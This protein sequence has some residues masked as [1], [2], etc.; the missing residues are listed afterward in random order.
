[1]QQG[2]VSRPD[3]SVGPNGLAQAGDLTGRLEPL[4]VPF[5]RF[6]AILRRHF[7]IVLLV[8]V[9]TVG[10]TAFVVKGIAKQY[11]SEASI[12]IEPQRTQVSD[13]QAISPDSG[14]V[15]SLVRTQIDILKS[16]A[17][18]MG[19]VRALHLTDE[20]EFGRHGE[21]LFAFVSPL[22]IKLGLRQAGPVRPPTEEDT[23][24]LAAA[25]LSAK[26]GFANETRSGVLRV[27][28]TTH[29]PDLSA[30]I[31]NSVVRQFLDFKRQEKFAA[32]QRAHD[33]FQ[34]QMREL[35]DQVR[36]AEQEVEK[37][38]QQH[39]LQ[40]E[41]PSEVAGVPRTATVN[42]QQLDAASRQL[43]DFSRERARREAQLVQAQAALRGEVPVRTLPEVLISPVIAQL[44][45]QTATVAAREAQLGDSQGANNPELASVRAQV[46]KLQHRT[47][48]EMANVAT[49]LT[50][51]VKAARAQEAALQQ[52]LEQLR[53]AVSTENSA[54]V[55]LQALQTQAR[56]KRSIYE[57]FLTRAT[58]LA[59]V[60]GIQE[61]DATLVSSAR[62][63]L[64]PSSPRVM[65]VL[66]LAAVLSI[67]LGVALACLIE[68]LRRGFS[69]PEQLEGALRLPLIALL[70]KVSGGGRRRPRK[71]RGTIAFAASLDRL[72]GQMRALGEGRPK[73]IMI[74]S[75]LPKEGKSIFAA[76][77]ASNAAAAGWRVL[78][79]ECDL[80][81]PSLAAQ[82]GLSPGPGLQDVLRG[83]ML[84]SNGG[85]IREAEPRL[86][87]MPAGSAGGDPQELLASDRMTQ[88]LTAVRT[89]YDLVI[90]DT[91]PVLPVADA[92]VL[93]RRA[94]ATLMVVQWETTARTAAED[95]L[96]LLHE[97]RAYVMGAVMTRANLRIAA[98]SGGRMSYLSS[99]YD[100]YQL[101]RSGQR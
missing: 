13:L 62:P 44:L 35:T 99:R 88:L 56:A 75:A 37:Y 93:A 64:S 4:A 76:G 32:M 24:A 22:I 65:R 23:I 52:R 59:N 98:A 81:C 84:G 43:V 89:H 3:N 29:D 94:D 2:M 8:F 72:R 50:T 21:G 70:P 7:W 58:Q 90:L 49:S 101:S 15:A 83:N 39:G 17:L 60:A 100:G 6:C 67:V 69:S 18:A 68:R 91:P 1:M 38:R 57:S 63:S 9:V 77:L 54:Q 97:S 73:L 66:A 41:S 26:I 92:L 5:H 31:A 80:G 55:G 42:R 47:E 36:T 45:N 96:R 27:L 74:T 12:L 40:E 46:R 71:G 34:E 61:P 10:G 14:D 48:Q 87:V 30:D 16:A 51:E 19:V 79:M 20:P 25:V 78:L 33:W 28:V 53:D 85:V 95:A 11:T 82:F 86:H